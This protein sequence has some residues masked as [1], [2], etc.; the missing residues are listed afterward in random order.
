MSFFTLNKSHI[1]ISLT[2][3]AFMKVYASVYNSDKDIAVARETAL[4]FSL[5]FMV[6]GMIGNL[7]NIFTLLQKKLR[8]HKF[9]LYLLAMSILKLIFCSTLFFDYIFS[10]FYSKSE[11]FHNFHRI[12]YIIID[13]LIHTSDSCISLLTLFLRSNL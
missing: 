1:S 9:N 6:I 4:I 2:P 5:I 12:S 7:I 8:E 13:F 10:Q 11:F 3:E